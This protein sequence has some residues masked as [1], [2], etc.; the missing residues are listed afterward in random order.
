MRERRVGLTIGQLLTQPA[1]GEPTRAPAVGHDVGHGLAAVGERHVLARLDR[2]HD[3]GGAV[4]QIADAD[5]HVLERST[6]VADRRIGEMIEAG[7]RAPD[8][9]LPNHDGDSVSLPDLRGRGVVL[10][11][12]PKADTPGC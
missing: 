4:A 3:I 1:A 11:F 2:S 9:T 8:F 5:L 6:L 7:A 12:Y 10:Y